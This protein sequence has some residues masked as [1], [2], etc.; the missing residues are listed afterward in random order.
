M[1]KGTEIATESR[2]LAFDIQRAANELVKT[3]N[4]TEIARELEVAGGAYIEA[5]KAHE[6]AAEGEQAA[7]AALAAARAGLLVHQEALRLASVAITK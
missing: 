2:D 3:K 4:F 1:R 6:A 5:K 7:G